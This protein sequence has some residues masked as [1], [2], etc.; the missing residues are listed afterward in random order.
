MRT[1]SRSNNVT[2]N[3][4]VYEYHR[5]SVPPVT[6][7]IL[8]NYNARTYQALVENMVDEMPKLKRSG[9]VSHQKMRRFIYPATLT[10]VFPHN[11]EYRTQPPAWPVYTHVFNGFSLFEKYVGNNYNNGF[12][13]PTITVPSTFDWMAM[14][15][16]AVKYMKPSLNKEGLLLNNFVKEA[17]DSASQARSRWGNRNSPYGPNANPPKGWARTIM[18]GLRGTAGFNLF[19]QFTLRP[20]ISDV[21]H[22]IDRV[23]T[24][25]DKLDQLIKMGNDV[26]TRHV[27]WPI[28]DR[29][30]LPSDYVFQ[31]V[32]LFGDYPGHKTY[33]ETRWQ[34]RPAYHATLRYKFDV[35][36]LKALKGSIRTYLD[37]FGVSDVL[38]TFWEAIPYSFL[39]D[40]FVNIGSWL[41]SIEN[42]LK[43]DLMPIQ[44]VDFSH[45]VK[46][47]YITRTL[48]DVGK[49]AWRIASGLVLYEQEYTYYVRRQEA[50]SLYDK[51]SVRLP[52]LNQALL[53]GSLYLAR[54]S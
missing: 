53:G 3:A 41:R 16:H 11:G 54:K 31:D 17:A 2:T 27:S 15:Y 45:S 44:I 42:A 43:G 33:V 25:E 6:T 14:S 51:L 49:G 22:I 46:F 39:V 13:S 35:S 21:N 10:Y 50:P 4:S 9:S 34:S 12:F 29:V 26:Q 52:N 47:N 30:T 24:L 8:F 28:T 20:T 5:L 18:R 1:R 37:A 7:P 48:L 38:P 40:W 32:A 19:Y 23:K 36:A